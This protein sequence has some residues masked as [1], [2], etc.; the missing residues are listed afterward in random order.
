MTCNPRRLLP[1]AIAAV[2]M[3]AT[4]ARAQSPAEFY[5]GRNVELYIGYS[6]GGALRPLCPHLAR[7][8]GKHIPGNP[9]VVPKNMEGAG[10][11][12]ARQLDLQCRRQGRHRDR[13]HRPRHRLRSAARLQGRAIPGRPLHLDRQRQQRGQRLRRL[14]DQRRHPARGRAGEGADRGRHRPG[15]R[16]RPVPAHPQRRARHQVQDRHRL[17]RR[18]R[19]RPSPWS[20]A[21]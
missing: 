13:H 8:L 14:E 21:R 10:S 12:R 9:N 18:Q 1:S 6:V 11:L 7:H 17:S 15:R 20:A 4:A 16:H 5:K 3:R 19:R 2:A